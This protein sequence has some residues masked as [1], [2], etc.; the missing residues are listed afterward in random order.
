MSFKYESIKSIRFTEPQV[1]S[2]Y[3]DDVNEF[4]ITTK[5]QP[6]FNDFKI[7]GKF[8]HDLYCRCLILCLY[9]LPKRK[10]KQLLEYQIAT[11]ENKLE[12]ISEVESL[13]HKNELLFKNS[14]LLEFY[15]EIIETIP[16]LLRQLMFDH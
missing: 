3:W 1:K 15:E 14:E 16:D 7:D 6:A 13:F 12:W 10:R 9:K 2:I 4:D 8:S 11:K 5:Y